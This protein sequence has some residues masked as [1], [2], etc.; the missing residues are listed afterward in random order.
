MTE[1]KHERYLRLK[2]E[3]QMK[4]LKAANKN[5]QKTVA[6][7]G[8]TTVAGLALAPKSHAYTVPTNQ[9]QTPAQRFLNKIIPA[10]Q[11]ATEGKDVYTSVMIAQ[12]ALESAWGTSAL[13]SEPNHNLFGVKGNYNGQSVNMYTLEDAGAQ[14]YYGIHDYFRKYPSYKESMDDYVDKIVNGIKG[15]P[16]FYSGAWKSRTNSYQDA[17]RYLTGRY[18]TDTAYYAKLNRIIEQFGLTKYDNGTATAIAASIE[19]KS[20]IGGQYTVQAGDTLYAISRKSGVSVNQLLSLNG[21]SLNSVIRPGQSLSLGNNTK[22]TTNTVVSTPV[23]TTSV[24]KANG[25]YTVKGGDTLYG[26][27]R[28]FGMSLSQL[29]SSNG[30]STSSIIRPGQTLRVVGGEASSTVVRTSTSTARTSSGNYV[31]QA[32]DTLYSIARRS[33]MSLNSLLTLNGLSQSSI[34]YPGQSLTVSQSE[35]NF[36]TPVSTKTNS[37]SSVVSTSGTYTVKAGDTLYSIARRSG[38]S[39]SSLL[40]LNGLSQSSVIRPGQT[41]NVSGTSSTTVATPVSTASQATSTSGTYTVKAGDTLYRIAHNHGISLRTLLSVNGLSETSTI[42]PGQQL[43]VSGSAQATTSYSSTQTVS[44]GAKTHT[45][46]AGEG[47][48]RIART[49][50]LSLEQLKALNGLTSNVIR[51]GQVL[52]VSK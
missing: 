40:S 51:V 5:L 32:G 21:L 17:T 42:R 3:N 2:K 20:S 37:A 7:V 29:I 19:E 26:I 48:W 15:A 44:S 1:T 50:G 27:S 38:V 11:Q 8:A 23:S 30:I 43:V 24:S 41:L 6:V 34:I 47:L 13:A 12:A 10:A 9:V 28:K 31:V 33:G 22:Q 4:A 46:K 45:V 35:G 52:K 25:T 18:A 14:N 16:M 49:Y 36:S 39:L